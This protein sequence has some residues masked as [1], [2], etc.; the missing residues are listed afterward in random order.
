MLEESV[1]YGRERRAFG[2]P[3]VV[4]M[5][6]GRHRLAEHHASLESSR[7]LTRRAADLF[8]RDEPALKDNSMAKLVSEIMKEIVAKAEGL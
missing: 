6:V 5:Q 8:N 7:W 3:L 4:A 2:R 1:R